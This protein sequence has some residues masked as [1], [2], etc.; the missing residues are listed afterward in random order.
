MINFIAA[1]KFILAQRIEELTKAIRHW[2][3][4]PR[5]KSRQEELDRLQDEWEELEEEDSEA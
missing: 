3:C 4:S 5:L 2:P 1:K